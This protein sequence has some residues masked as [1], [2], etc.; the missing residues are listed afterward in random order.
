MAAAVADYAPAAASHQKIEKHGQDGA[1]T[2]RLEPTPDILA[3]LGTR[4]GES[5]RP[6][7]VGFAAQTGDP[8]PAAR[9]K[10]SAKRVDLIVA[11]DVTM[12]GAGFDV[13]TNQVTLVSA[14]GPDKDEPLPMQ[15][16][17]DVA[18]AILDRVERLL[19]RQPAL[20]PR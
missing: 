6:V 9:R 5:A 16:K 3:E 18:R 8:V 13:T 14:D 19:V 4:R 2:L 1:L 17:A 10:L 15:S 7:L 20:A 11:N 12:P